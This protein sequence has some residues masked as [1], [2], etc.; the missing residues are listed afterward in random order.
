MDREPLPI[1]ERDEQ[2]LESYGLTPQRPIEFF[3]RR[4][5]LLVIFMLLSLGSYALYWFY[6]N[7]DAVRKANGQKMWPLVRAIF[8]IFWAW[9]LFKLM[10]LQARARGSTSTFSGGGLALFYI[11]PLL[12]AGTGSSGKDTF[13]VAI[14]GSIIASII[15]ALALVT[16]Q[17][18]AR[19]AQYARTQEDMPYSPAGRW[20][21][22][23]VLLFCVYPVLVGLL[24][25]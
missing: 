18:L 21:G 17:R 20:E 6:R 23:F 12:L 3:S 19:F 14:G 1:T 4:P 15:A 10:V 8:A 13:N 7:W 24:S 2:F 5:E 9:P 11:L 25:K 16:A 22:L